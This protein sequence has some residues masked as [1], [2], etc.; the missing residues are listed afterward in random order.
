VSLRI[1]GAAPF[2][3]KKHMAERLKC[4]LCDYVVTAAIP[5]DVLDDGDINQQY[6]Y[7]ARSMMAIFKHFSGIPY[8]H[9]Q[10]LND[11]FGC[12]ITASTAFDQCEKVANA[13]MPI[14]HQLRRDAA[15]AVVF[16]IDDTSNRILDQKG[17]ERPNR[18][19]QGSRMRTGIYTSGM[20]AITHAGERIY[21]YHTSL[22]HAGEFLDEIL[23]LR[24]KN[25]PAPIIMSD[26]LSS[27]LPTGSLETVTALCNAHARRQFFSIVEQ[28]PDELEQLL[29]L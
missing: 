15:N 27:N 18:N 20:I 26:A 8:Y 11:L 7:S 2:D 1:T 25:L 5:Q 19:G 17:E 21:L 23:A 14:Y 4:N 3:A 29:D 24:E 6:G 28:H 12:P 9:L 13:C 10:T 22:G 16:H